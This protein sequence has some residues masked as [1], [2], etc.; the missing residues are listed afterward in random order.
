MGGRGRREIY[1][2]ED[3]ARSVV[4]QLVRLI[5]LDVSGHFAYVRFH[6]GDSSIEPP[7]DLFTAFH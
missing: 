5:D 3:F 7:L 6:V 1:P 4:S 2:L